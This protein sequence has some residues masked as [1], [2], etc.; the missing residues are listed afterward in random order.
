MERHLVLPVALF[1]AMM[2]PP[3]ASAGRAKVSPNELAQAV[4]QADRR[5][6]YYLNTKISPADIR[7]IKCVGPDEEPTE[8]E[9]E[10]RQ[11]VG[12]RWIGRKT[13]LAIDGSGWHD[14]D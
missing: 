6:V 13:W 10:W 12:H 8:F 7:I 14:I 2:L 3:M 9:C 5:A 1:M 11:R 4:N